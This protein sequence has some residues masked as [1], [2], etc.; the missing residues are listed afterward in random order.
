MVKLIQLNGLPT[1]P[2]TF[3]QTS[4]SP[5]SD[6]Y[7]ENKIQP[8]GLISVVA[9]SKYANAS[10]RT[11]RRQHFLFG[12]RVYADAVIRSNTDRLIS[13]KRQNKKVS[14]G[15]SVFWKAQGSHKQPHLS[16]WIWNFEYLSSWAG[17]RRS[18]RQQLTFVFLLLGVSIFKLVYGLRGRRHDAW[19]L[20]WGRS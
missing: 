8:V 18:S 12:L 4:F 15:R 17:Y 14:P 20:K 6:A 1:P 7:L 13:G 3:S 5:S 11:T 9:R 10:F 2:S 16:V 19:R